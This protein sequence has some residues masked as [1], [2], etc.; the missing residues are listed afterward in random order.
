ME[1]LHFLRSNNV[2]FATEA[3]TAYIINYFDSDYDGLLDPEDL[4]Y[5]VLPCDNPNLRSAIA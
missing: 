3:D 2:E 4:L 1:L 5:L